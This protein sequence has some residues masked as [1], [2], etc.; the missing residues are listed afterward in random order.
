MSLSVL[1]LP[2][3]FPHFLVLQ[4]NDS[5]LEKAA[6]LYSY[7]PPTTKEGY[8]FRQ[9][10]EKHYP[11]RCEWIPHYWMPRWIKA[12]D[13]SARTLAIYKPDKDQ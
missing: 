4:I 3:S 9:V 8:Y 1:F 7:N 13:P 2:H 11:G 5:Q 10:F 6:K 12:T